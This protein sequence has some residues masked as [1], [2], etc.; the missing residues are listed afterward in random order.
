VVTIGEAMAVIAH[1]LFR[2][3]DRKQYRGDAERL[4]MW[5]YVHITAPT[6]GQKRSISSPLKSLDRE[7]FPHHR[8]NL[9]FY[10]KHFGI[11]VSGR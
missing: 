4:M 9:G 5:T 1:L 7:M 8:L 3:V 2:G 6:T 10:V 11:M